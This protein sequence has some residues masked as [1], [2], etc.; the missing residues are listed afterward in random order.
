V[1]GEG[2]AEVLRSTLRQRPA[3]GVAEQTEHEAE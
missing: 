3:D 1:A 2:V